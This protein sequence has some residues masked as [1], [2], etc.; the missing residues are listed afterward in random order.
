MGWALIFT[1]NVGHVSTKNMLIFFTK[2]EGEDEPSP[3]KQKISKRIKEEKKF[4][5]L[6][7][8]KGLSSNIVCV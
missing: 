5:Y 2:G 8:C 4:R 3:R 6:K 1:Y 7:F